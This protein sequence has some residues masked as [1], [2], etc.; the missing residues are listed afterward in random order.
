MLLAIVQK[1]IRSPS[2]QRQ[3]A[4]GVSPQYSSYCMRGWTKFC[5]YVIDIINGLSQKFLYRFLI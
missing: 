4:I 1:N 5:V 2:R 3:Y